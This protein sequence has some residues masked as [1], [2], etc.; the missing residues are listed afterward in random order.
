MDNIAVI[1]TLA[2]HTWLWLV[3]RSL[4]LSL[5]SDI[6][7]PEWLP[8]KHE[9]ADLRT[10]YPIFIGSHTVVVPLVSRES[11]RYLVAPGDIP[12]IH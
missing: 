8:L 1:D 5:A 11:L 9:D 12:K 7:A 6:E 4:V 3:Q 2:S 10:E